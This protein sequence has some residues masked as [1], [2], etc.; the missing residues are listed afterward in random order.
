[1]FGVQDRDFLVKIFDLSPFIWLRMSII[2]IAA[3]EP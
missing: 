1:M 3:I 2:V